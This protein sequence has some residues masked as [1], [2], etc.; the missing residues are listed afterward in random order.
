[1]K[2]KNNAGVRNRELA[3]KSGAFGN[4]SERL[5]IKLYLP[6]GS[7]PFIFRLSSI[8]Q[9]GLEQPSPRGLIRNREVEKAS[10]VDV[11]DVVAIVDIYAFQPSGRVPGCF[12]KKLQP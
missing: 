3:T 8:E 9:R 11:V 10:G 12:R 2:R 6:S 7:L 5:L 1:M 4:E